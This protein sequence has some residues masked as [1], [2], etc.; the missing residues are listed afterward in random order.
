MRKLLRIFRGSKSKSSSLLICLGEDFS[1]V[2]D[3]PPQLH[4][5]LQSWLQSQKDLPPGQLFLL[6]NGTRAPKSYEHVG[7]VINCCDLQALQEYILAET[8]E[9]ADGQLFRVLGE[10][11]N[12]QWMALSNE[13]TLNEDMLTKVAA[14]REHTIPLDVA[15]AQEMLKMKQH[16][17][18]YA[19]EQKAA[20]KALDEM[21]GQILPWRRFAAKAASIVEVAMAVEKWHPLYRGEGQSCLQWLWH[22]LRNAVSDK[23]PVDE[24]TT[25]LPRA[26]VA[27]AV[28]HTFPKHHPS[29]VCSVAFATNSRSRL[30]GIFS[31]ALRR[32]ANGEDESEE[33]EATNP[34]RDDTL[35][36]LEESQQDDREP[37][38]RP[39]APAECVG[40]IT[41]KGWS[42]LTDYKDAFADLWKVFDSMVQEPARWTHLKANPEEALPVEIGPVEE[43]LT[44]A[45]LAPERLEEKL[46]HLSIKELG[47]RGVE[48]LS[49]SKGPVALVTQAVQDARSDSPPKPILFLTEEEPGFD[50][51]STVR[52]T[53]QSL[54]AQMDVP[55]QAVSLLDPLC[56]AQVGAAHLRFQ[57][58]QAGWLLLEDTLD[59]SLR[60]LETRHPQLLKR[61]DAMMDLAGKASRSSAGSHL[62]PPVL[63][64]V[65]YAYRPQKPT[66]FCSLLH[67]V[68]KANRFA[69]RRVFVSWPVGLMANI[70]AVEAD[71]KSVKDA[72]PEHE[73]TH[74]NLSHLSSLH[75][76]LQHR[77]RMGEFDATNSSWLLEKG[78]LSHK[79]DPQ[80]EQKLDIA[81]LCK[82][83]LSNS[84]PANL[85][86]VLPEK[87]ASDLESLGW[88]SLQ[89]AMQEALQKHQRKRK[90]RTSRPTNRASERRM[91]SLCWRSQSASLPDRRFGAR[92]LEDV[93]LVTDSRL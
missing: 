32:S 80:Q 66:S 83:V 72:E 5:A 27:A 8:L 48:T 75:A 6:S 67:L 85:W 88:R 44:F 64:A 68:P 46:L 45:A 50:C 7:F 25:E 51:A 31:A 1:K 70:R 59:E 92:L 54:A 19:E 18:E 10:A 61:L 53:L 86:A 2:D 24:L 62:G 38:T 55:F 71:I 13:K 15:L 41:D 40:F 60:T 56:A 69:A 91:Y 39:A 52:M 16:H 73:T 77:S 29:L 84:W 90:K 28:S 49:A 93:A 3:D 78:T 57:D 4:P 14:D 42:R 23:I 9:I 35:E 22:Y 17:V 30:E 20:A 12:K 82:D 37:S 87:L 11:T 65:H 76:L 36:D 34:Q 33:K 79:A 89:Q 63:V 81:S 58:Q 21:Q 43:L 26:W 47:T 74:D